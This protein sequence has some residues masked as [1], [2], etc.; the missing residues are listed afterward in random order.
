M[1]EAPAQLREPRLGKVVISPEV[2]QARV[3]ELAAAVSRDYRD[4]DLLLLAVLNGAVPFARDLSRRLEVRH[5]LDF[6]GIA[7]YQSG[8]TGERVRIILWPETPLRGMDILLVE[9][10]VDTGLTLHY[11]VGVLGR[12]EPA[13]LRVISLLERPELRLADL[14]LDYVGFHV[15]ESFL[16]GYGLDFEDRY[17]GLPCIAELEW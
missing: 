7:R 2:L 11:L 14:R 12:Q 13:S 1:N 9:D 5:E 15:S 6:L 10:I 8:V 17:R 16:V 4:G 3:A